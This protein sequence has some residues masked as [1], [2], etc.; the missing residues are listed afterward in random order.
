MDLFTVVLTDCSLYDLG[1][2]R[3]HFTWSNNR[4]DSYFT[5]ENLLL[6]AIFFFF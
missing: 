5:K 3:G 4:T 2:Y 6:G 1:F